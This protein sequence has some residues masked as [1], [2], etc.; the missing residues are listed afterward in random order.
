LYVLIFMFL[1]NRRQDRFRMKQKKLK[2]GKKSRKLY[3]EVKC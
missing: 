2:R 3:I 1:H